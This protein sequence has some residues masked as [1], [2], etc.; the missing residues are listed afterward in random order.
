M[1]F[2]ISFAV[3]LAL[4]LP[5]KATSV[6]LKTKLR[7][8]IGLG[9]DAVSDAP[10]VM[11]VVTLLQ[12]MKKQLE[13]ELQD[14]KEVHDKT[15]CW[16]D[17]NK[18]EKTHSIE[19]GTTET[20][21]L[22][23]FISESKANIVEA[24]LQ[25]KSARS[26][27]ENDIKAL[28]AA[29][30][31]R[32]K[33]HKAFGAD[34]RDL[35]D[36][37]ESSQDAITV[38][39]AGS[40][41]ASLLDIR[42]IAD[43]LQTAQVLGKVSLDNLRKTQLTR[44]LHQASGATS[45][46][47]IPG[48][49][50]HFRSDA[51]RAAF[52]SAPGTDGPV[53]GIL[54]Q[55]HHDFSTDLDDLRADEAKA[56]SK[57]KALKAAKDEQISSNQKT[58]IELDKRL[59]SLGEKK[60]QASKDLKS[61]ITQVADDKALL[62]KLEKKCAEHDDEYNTRVKDRFAEMEAVGE[63]I[64]ILNNEDSFNLFDKS[65]VSLL[66]VSSSVSAREQFRRR[67]AA[68]ALE[69]AAAVIN[70]PWLALM[71]GQVRLD[72]FTHVKKAIGSMVVQLTKQQKDEIDH[73]DWCVKQLFENKKDTSS[74]EDKKDGVDV[75]TDELKMSIGELKKDISNSKSTVAEIQLQMKQASGNREGQN[76]DYQETITDQRMTQ[77]VLE[78]AITRMK[79]VY[80]LLQSKSHQHGS[81]RHGQ[82]QPKDFRKYEKNANGAKVILM[83]EEIVGDSRKSEADAIRAEQDAQQTYEMFMM[84]SNKALMAAS[85]KLSTQSGNLANADEQLVRVRRDHA[86]IVKKLENL[87][88]EK[89]DLHKSCD[90]IMQN[91]KTRQDS[92][93]A[94]KNALK[95]AMSILSG[96]S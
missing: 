36:A 85:E 92:R 71:A 43:K 73:K 39:A 56:V 27:M 42:R 77:M 84:G 17:T 94:E 91:F 88:S 66:Q 16:C 72:K 40:K 64:S 68:S 26:D 53:L 69:R 78:K 57:Y 10:P 46:L 23:S 49:P 2:I 81:R 32:M 82:V 93:A 44:F 31:L 34:E 38:L 95:E 25:R 62:A 14:D 35:V 90:Y 7:E 80:A 75:K 76:A 3:A 29:T 86:G 59:G 58:L 70:A 54:K 52:L 4:P 96:G 24:E 8:D 83:L 6:A 61:T 89:D 65:L 47:S 1:K 60:A 18:I 28:S 13:F 45:L 79:Q 63:A 11:K 20:E 5:I 15:M 19:D 51:S 41:R 37:V 9:L 74:A 55:M 87:S 33:E 48:L 67:S 22:K 30:A 12:D 50:S 21:Q